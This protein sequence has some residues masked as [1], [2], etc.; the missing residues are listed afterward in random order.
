MAIDR[1]A[2][3]SAG[4]PPRGSDKLLGGALGKGGLG[5]GDEEA[6][7]RQ[8]DDVQHRVGAHL[9]PGGDARTRNVRS[10]RL[11]SVLCEGEIAMGI[12]EG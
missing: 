5:A 9:P 4:R 2:G 3:K 1:S 11:G 7:H 10:A 8:R 6:G 12:Q